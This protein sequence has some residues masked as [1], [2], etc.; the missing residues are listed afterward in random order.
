MAKA[1]VRRNRGVIEA[2]EDFLIDVQF[3]IQDL[4][5]RKRVSRTELAEMIGISKARL[6]QLMGSEANPTLKTFAG[7]VHALGEKIVVSSTP[8]DSAPSALAPMDLG[9]GWN[10]ISDAGMAAEKRSD[11]NDARMVEL[12]KAFLAS[13]DNDAPQAVLWDNVSNA[14]TLKAA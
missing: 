4:I 5:N 7:V 2:E 9:P 3:L 12:A 11:S 10:Q 8:I 14:V 6:S 13:N 1:D